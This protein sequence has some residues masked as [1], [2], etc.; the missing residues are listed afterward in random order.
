MRRSSELMQFEIG[1]STRR[2]FPAR[3]TAGLAR[4]LVSGKSR[5]PAPPPIITD[6]TLLVLASW[7][8]VCDIAYDSPEKLNPASAGTASTI[9]VASTGEGASGHCPSPGR[10]A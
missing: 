3:G 7:R 6:S 10:D 4:S 2:Y 9:A 1:M 5:V 8:L